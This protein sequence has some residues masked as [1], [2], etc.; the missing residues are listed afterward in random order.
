MPKHAA[1]VADM[2]QQLQGVATLL[3]EKEGQLLAAVQDAH[4][5]HIDLP[6]MLTELE[7]RA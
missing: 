4:E 7:F 2:R 6:V 5:L 1:A 3:L